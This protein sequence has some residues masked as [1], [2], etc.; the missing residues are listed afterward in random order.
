MLQ[1]AFVERIGTTLAELTMETLNDEY[2]TVTN[3]GDHCDL[4]ITTQTIWN[5][6]WSLFQP[7][8]RENHSQSGL[9][10]FR[11]LQFNFADIVADP[12]CPAG[13]I[14][15]L[16]TKYWKLGVR[17]GQNFHFRPFERPVDQDA[18][19]ASFMFKGNI[20]CTDPGKQGFMSGVVA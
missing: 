8:Q 20:I 13:Y 10:G 17:S 4:I 16:N 14:F 7:A 5:K 18:R 12:Y 6:I 11:T 3:G 9:V 19:V 2:G 15:F 1:D